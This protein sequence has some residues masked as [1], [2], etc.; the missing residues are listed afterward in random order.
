[1]GEELGNPH[2]IY[3][4]VIPENERPS[5]EEMIKTA[6]TISAVCRRMTERG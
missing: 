5:R 1:M 4:E 2:P 6:I 3:L